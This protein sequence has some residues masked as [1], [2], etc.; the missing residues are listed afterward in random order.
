VLAFFGLRSR[1]TART[2][3]PAAKNMGASSNH[4]ASATPIF[5]LR[6]LAHSP[7]AHCTR[8]RRINSGNDV[9]PACTHHRSLFQQIPYFR[10]AGRHRLQHLLL[11]GH[12]G[13]L[14]I[15][16]LLA[17]LRG[18][19]TPR[20]LCPLH[21]P[22]V[23]RLLFC[24]WRRD[25]RADADGDSEQNTARA[26]FRGTRIEAALWHINL[27]TWEA[28]SCLVLVGI[29]SASCL[30]TAKTWPATEDMPPSA[31]PSCHLLAPG[32]G[33]FVAPPHLTHTFTGILLSAFSLI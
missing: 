31:L 20:N 4:F 9:P 10:A 6:A 23:R 1:M 7:C 14:R 29:F 17:R 15:R 16:H 25:E 28:V 21:A 22:R 27:K 33:P 13:F 19:A 2:H 32:Q 12:F 30:L 11:A 24:T 8:A 3:S 26:S 5:C 18:A